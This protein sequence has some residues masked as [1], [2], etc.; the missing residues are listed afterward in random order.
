MDP[1]VDA[2]AQTRY[3]PEPK[4]LYAGHGPYGRRLQSRVCQPY[5]DSTRANR[6]AKAANRMVERLRPMLS[7]NFYMEVQE[8]WPPRGSCLRRPDQT[9]CSSLG[10]FYG[11]TALGR[12]RGRHDSR[13]S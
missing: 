1:T 2:Y 3:R 6:G 7:L 4:N 11:N 8:K 5:P 12:F 13:L 10:T 9:R